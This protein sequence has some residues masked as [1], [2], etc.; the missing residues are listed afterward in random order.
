LNAARFVKTKAIAAPSAVAKDRKITIC[1][2][3]I[4]EAITTL[5]VEAFSPKSTTP[6]KA[7][8]TPSRGFLVLKMIRPFQF[9]HEYRFRLALRALELCLK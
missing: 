1:S 7:K 9:G 5:D 3:V 8:I 2:G 6:D 4:P